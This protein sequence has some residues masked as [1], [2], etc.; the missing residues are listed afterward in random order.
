MVRDEWMPTNLSVANAEIGHHNPSAPTPQ[1][2]KNRR[3]IPLCHLPR[4]GAENRGGCARFCKSR[5]IESCYHS[6]FCSSLLLRPKPLLPALDRRRV[7]HGVG[8]LA[9]EKRQ[10]ALR[11]HALAGFE[12]AGIIA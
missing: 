4:R 3:K 8:Q 5:L 7:D 2:N 6:A 9:F 11:R 10:D 1:P 12:R